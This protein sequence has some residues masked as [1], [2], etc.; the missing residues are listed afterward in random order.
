[1]TNQANATVLLASFIGAFAVLA[2]IQG[3]KSKTIVHIHNGQPVTPEVSNCPPAALL[4][5]D[6][7]MILDRSGSMGSLKEQ[8]VTSF[9]DFLEEQKAVDGEAFISLIQFDD[10]YEPNYEGVLLDQAGELTT[11]TYEPRGSTALFD[12][13]GRAITEA[14]DRI[15]LG[16]SDVVFVITTDGLENASTN[17]SGDVI[18]ELIAECESEFGWHFM[19]LAANQ[20]AFD[21]HETIGIRRRGSLQLEATPEGWGA[22]QKDMSQRV[23]EFRLNENRDGEQL[24][25]EEEDDV[26]EEESEDMD[27]GC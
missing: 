24:E 22:A 21:Q 23:M 26:K 5:V 4:P 20:E 11:S 15:Q 17:Y 1:M 8:V 3:C 12:A 7:T 27:D 13:I 9:N 14:K 25:F 6:I 16:E 19:Y 10:K 18:K 2:A